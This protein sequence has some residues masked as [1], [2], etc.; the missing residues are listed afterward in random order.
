MNIAEEILSHS[1]PIAPAVIEAGRT[2]SYDFLEIQSA[3]V[4]HSL[5]LRGN[6]KG[7]CIGLNCNDGMYYIVLALGILRSGAC[8]VPLASEL[9]GVERAHLIET[10]AL[11][12]VMTAK[13]SAP[14][15][16][17]FTLEKKNPLNHKQNHE[18]LH[19]LNPAFIRFSS[20]TTGASKG[21]VL[22]HE[23]LRARIEA[24]NQGLQIDS[25]DRILWVLSMAHHFIVSIMLYLW[26]GACLVIPASHLA[27]DILT[28]AHESAV[29]VLYGA[30]CH[31]IFLTSGEESS[32]ALAW[33]SLRLAVSTTAPLVSEVGEKFFA[34][35]GIYPVQA[36]GIMEVGLPFLNQ[37]DRPMKLGSVGKPQA[38]FEIELRAADGGKVAAECAGELFVKGPGMFDAYSFPWA[39]REQI[40]GL[41]G[42][43]CTG[44]IACVDKEGFLFLQGR[45]VSQINV[46]GLK[47]F[48][49]EVESLLCSHDGVSK[50]RVFGREHSIF[51]MLPIAEIVRVHDTDEPV[52]ALQLTSL[53]KKEL[54][55]YKVPV[56]IRFV[57]SIP[58]T[59]TGKIKRSGTSPS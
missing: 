10:L 14:E 29:T 56:E 6:G 16:W 36:L 57:E 46:G 12:A 4:A 15:N 18:S 19:A 51:G 1:N 40:T 53:C 2:Y 35:Y 26:R 13:G 5:M 17:S 33:P 41:D 54:A 38:G 30:P 20:G 49:E 22:S 50:A 39:T 24:A 3:A 25:D 55:K 31:F 23:T 32:I 34:F 47:F 58:Q 28:A 21:I 8:L 43:F 7:D 9:S 27:G 44:D 52:S 59:S 42:W 11:D 45:T 37:A 48:P